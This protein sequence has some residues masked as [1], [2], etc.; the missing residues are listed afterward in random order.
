M[1]YLM[2]SLV[3]LLLCGCASV[4]GPYTVTNV[5]DGDTLDVYERVR[6]S[7]IN[8]PETGECY[9]QEAKDRLGDLVLGKEVYLE[10]DVSDRGKYGRLLRYVYVSGENVN[11]LLV[12]EGYAKV[13]DKYASD[14]KMYLELKALE[15]VAIENELGV[16]GC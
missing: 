1:R 16:W 14:T 6:L 10:S 12:E 2:I 15:S 7:G 5:V 3:I 8:T 13:H 11:L 9:Y 4:E